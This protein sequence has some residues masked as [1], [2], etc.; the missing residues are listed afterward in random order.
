MEL[1]DSIVGCL[2][3]FGNFERSGKDAP[4]VMI[5]EYSARVES[6]FVIAEGFSCSD[7][8]YISTCDRQGILTEAYY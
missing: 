8:A 1:S 7:A 5:H 2:L 3:V 4:R 6:V